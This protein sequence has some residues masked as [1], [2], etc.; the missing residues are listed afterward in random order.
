[1]VCQHTAQRTQ[2]AQIHTVAASARSCLCS[3]ELKF[4]HRTLWVQN[5][6]DEEGVTIIISFLLNRAVEFSLNRKGNILAGLC[7]LLLPQ[8]SANFRQRVLIT[9]KWVGVAQCGQERRKHSIK[10]LEQNFP[11]TF[12]Q[13]LEFTTAKEAFSYGFGCE[14]WS[15]FLHS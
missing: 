1:M 11:T 3:A 14:L 6:D 7:R 2:T 10:T 15:H 5:D 4:F 9:L 8:L 13:E 12:W